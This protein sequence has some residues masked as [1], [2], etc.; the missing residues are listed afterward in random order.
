MT[1]PPGTILFAGPN[2]DKGI[3]AAKKYIKE[4]GYTDK[5]IKLFTQGDDVLVK[6]R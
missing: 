4:Q 3:E 1:Y 2:N 5:E 6:V